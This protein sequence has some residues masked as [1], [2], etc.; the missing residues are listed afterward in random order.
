MLTALHEAYQGFEKC[1]AKASS[2]L[3]Q[4]P[5]QKVAYDLLELDNKHY[6][7]VIDYYYRYFE[8]AQLK[9]KTTESIIKAMKNIFVTH[10]IP[11]VC[12][13]DN[14]RCYSSAHFKQFAL[15]YGFTHTTSSP[16]FAQAN[17]EA[18]CAVHTAKKIL[19]KSSDPYLGLPYL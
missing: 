12:H 5:W 17:S 4:Y 6:I 19:R 13:G 2:D 9:N 11:I 18:E 16:R 8:V 14:G 1:R 10:G 3:P 7:I 15:N